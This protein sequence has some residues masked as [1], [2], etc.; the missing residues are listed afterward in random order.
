MAHES[1]EEPIG[2]GNTISEQT[3]NHLCE[4]ESC[5]ASCLESA[6]K[7]LVEPLE[8]EELWGLAHI[9]ELLA[10]EAKSLCDNVADI[11]LIAKE[12]KHD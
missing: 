6:L 8:H 1:V 5:K 12:V 4:M 11:P 3:L 2:N 10:K 9:V 7:T